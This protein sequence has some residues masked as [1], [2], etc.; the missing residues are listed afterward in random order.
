MIRAQARGRGLTLSII[1]A[2]LAATG[3]QNDLTIVSRN[4]SD[5]GVVGWSV[6]NLWEAQA[7]KLLKGT[8]LF[9]MR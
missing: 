6:V 3:L 9:A 4:V 2:L 7:S 5:Y 8:R 1:D